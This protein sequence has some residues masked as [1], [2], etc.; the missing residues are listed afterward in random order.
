LV[1]SFPS[2]TEVEILNQI[3]GLLDAGHDVRIFARWGSAA[4]PVHPEIEEYGLLGRVTYFGMP[5]IRPR[6]L[7][8]GAALAIKNLPRSP[9]KVLRP[10]NVFKYGVTSLTLTPL[11]ASLHFPEEEFDVVH[12]HFGPNGVIGSFLRD[13]G[14]RGKLI[15]SFHGHDAGSYPA[16]AGKNVYRGLFSNADALTA[17]T[18]FLKERMVELGCEADK[19]L[20]I[21]SAIMVDRLKYRPRTIEGGRPIRLLSVGR[22]VEKKGFAYSIRAFAD[23]VGRFEN[24]EYKIVGEGPLRN[25]LTGLVEELG[26][27]DKVKFMG[28]IGWDR[29]PDLYDEA[30][31]FVL[32]S[33]T[34]ARQD[35]EGQVLT[36]QEAQAAGMPVVSTLHNGI[37]EGVRDGISG[38]LVPER[39]VGALA[40]RLAQLV[41]HPERWPEIGRAGRDFVV[42]RYDRMVITHRLI[43]IYEALLSGEEERLKGFHSY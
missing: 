33:V 12:C 21:P 10:L 18:E 2:I 11:F 37:P 7:A 31:I 26:I 3:T 22:L 39:D 1:S 14:I 15:A 42:H 36:V 20:I 35:H 23:L 13:Q 24:V 40:N 4:G 8:R 43:G 17:N 25:E 27:G 29:M 9:M 32:A 6:R 41:E 19:V 30:D 16:V 28:A 34:S 5:S 38:F